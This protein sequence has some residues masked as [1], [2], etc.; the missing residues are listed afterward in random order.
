[1][2]RQPFVRTHFDC[3]PDIVKPHVSTSPKN[4]KNNS[5]NVQLIVA[6]AS[7]HIRHHYI[8]WT[9]FLIAYIIYLYTF[10]AKYLFATHFAK[11]CGPTDGCVY[12]LIA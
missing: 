9:P 10:L 12:S 2:H 4:T 6:E 8:Y 1:M 11:P 3:L 7:L 5:D